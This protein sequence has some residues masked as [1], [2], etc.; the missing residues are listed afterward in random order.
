M[1]VSLCVCVCL[2]CERVICKAGR[3]EEEGVGRVGAFFPLVAAAFPFWCKPRRHPRRTQNT[4]THGIH[5]THRHHARNLSAASPRRMQDA[6]CGK[7]GVQKSADAPKKPH[8]T[9]TGTRTDT[10][11]STLGIQIYGHRGLSSPSFP[12][13]PPPAF[14][15]PLDFAYI[16]MREVVACADGKLTAKLSLCWH[17]RQ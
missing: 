6:A 7:L 9:H 14:S 12:F 4:Y 16:G 5:T 3:K 10:G 1:C 8:K 15:L 13:S 2:M 17:T 11:R